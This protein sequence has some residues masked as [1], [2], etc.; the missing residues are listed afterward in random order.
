MKLDFAKL[1]VFEGVMTFLV[2]VIALTFVFAFKATEGKS[3]K[4]AATGSPTA[5]ATGSG[6]TGGGLQVTAADYSFSPTELTVKAGAAATVTL[7]NDGPATHNLRI[8]GADNTFNTDDDAVTDPLAVTAGQTATIT[9]TA[10]TTAG[11]IKFQ[12]DFHPQQMQGTIKV[13]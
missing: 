13:Q 11:D 7:K 1:P 5:A 2:I 6:G 12:C 8:A 3:E 9:W 4:G 10:P